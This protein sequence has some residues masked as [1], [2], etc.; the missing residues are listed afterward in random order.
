[1]DY[2]ISRFEKMNE[3]YFDEVK[4]ELTAGEEE[5][6]LDVVH[7]PADQGTRP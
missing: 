5:L 1:M 6:A 4:A 7:F 2:D 3:G